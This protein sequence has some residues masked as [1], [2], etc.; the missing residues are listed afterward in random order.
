MRTE[1]FEGLSTKVKSNQEIFKDF[2][3]DFIDTESIVTHPSI[4]EFLKLE[5]PENSIG[6][7][8]TLTETNF[9]QN[10]ISLFFIN[11]DE[12]FEKSLNIIKKWQSSYNNIEKD[13]K[14]K[15]LI[16]ITSNEK[17]KRITREAR[18]IFELF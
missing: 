3:I 4:L 7:Y 5:F 1:I 2:I 10:D 12:L 17:I 14:K 13:N 6:V 15:N 16:I 8:N 11:N 9:K 18:E